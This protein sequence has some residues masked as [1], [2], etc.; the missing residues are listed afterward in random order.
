[1]NVT[2]L[3]TVLSL[4]GPL[5]EDWTE[6]AGVKGVEGATVAF[7]D[8]DGDGRPDAVLD[9]IKVFLARG[10]KLARQAGDSVFLP[11]LD[12]RRPQAVQFGDVNGDGHLDLFLCF[13]TDLKNPEFK[14]DGR[15]NEL[16]IGDGTGNFIFK[17]DSGLGERGE[18]TIT[19][20][21]VDFDRDGNLDLFKGNWYV[22]PFKAPE[23]F[24]SRLYRG[25]GDG[26]FAE[27]TEKAGILG[28][29]DASKREGR[30][31]VFGVTHTDWNNDG[32]Q[33]LLVCVYGRQWNVLWKNNGDGTFTDVA[34]A[35]TFDGDADRSGKYSDE[36][37][38]L[39]KEKRN[40]D[41]EDEPPHRVNG[42]TFDCAV[43]DFDNDGDMDCFLAEIAHWWAG[44]SSDRSMLLV[45]QGP[46]AGFVFKR[47]PERIKRKHEVDRWNE[48][49]LNAGWLDVDNDG[50][51]DLIIASSDYPDL[52]ILRLYRQ[53]PDGSFEDW[54]DRL[55]FRWMNAS[56]ISLGD[57]DRDGA[58]DILVGTNNMRLTPEQV[59]SRPLSVGLFRNAHAGRTGN[60]YFNLRLKGQAV[61]ARV[62]I[63]TDGRRQIREVY[64]GL[65][66]AGHRDDTD[67][68]FGV[69]K[70]KVIDE[71][72]VRW[73]D[74]AGTVQ[75][76]DKVEPNRFYTLEK[77]G[78]LQGA[79]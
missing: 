46:E 29:E 4:Q 8:L 79:K 35:T 74:A 70:A 5:F 22:Q 64:G 37:K 71:V 33:D 36:V 65:G 23:C 12:A 38:K 10:G 24:P 13:M 27:V 6:R 45:N 42:N 26:T 18:L 47:D 34:E 32:L 77:G 41:L 75:K 69:G 1:M 56:Q 55:R 11:K 44:P 67:C 52:Q 54:T 7:A 25:R 2:L 15:R 72:V 49:D 14:D 57:F 59:A 78:K 60:G 21:F 9:R 40:L 68:R 76:F 51:L 61:G 43:A 28:I 58:T 19:A 16:W 63:R 50:W 48:G 62:T 53:M 39:F 20:C 73:P 17:K 30:R 31:P 3:A 66:H